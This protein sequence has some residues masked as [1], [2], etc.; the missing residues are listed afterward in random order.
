MREVA[1]R[2]SLYLQTLSSL[3]RVAGLGA[4]QFG[5]VSLVTDVHGQPHAL[6]SLW[7]GQL[8][9]SGSVGAVVR[10]RELLASVS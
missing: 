1:A 6:K 7:K 3:R 9:T 8:I 5:C 10:E 4:G 2:R